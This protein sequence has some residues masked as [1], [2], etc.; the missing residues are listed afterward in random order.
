MGQWEVGSLETFYPSKNQI[1]I[2]A[3]IILFDEKKNLKS[4]NSNFWTPLYTFSVQLMLKPWALS[5]IRNTITK[6]TVSQLLSRGT[7]KFEVNI[8]NDEYGLDFFGRHL[9]HVLRS[10]VQNEFGM[11]LRRNGPH[12]P[13]LAQDLNRIHILMTKRVT[14]ENNSVCDANSPMLRCFSFNATLKPRTY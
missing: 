13:E 7:Q 8:A 11:E 5:F 4:Q 12:R 1:V 3:K 14:I 6:K 10:K 9:E 2:K